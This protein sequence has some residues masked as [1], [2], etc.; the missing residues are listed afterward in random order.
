MAATPSTMLP[1]GT[2]APSFALPYVVSGATISLETFADKKALL[3]I[4]LCRHCRYVQHVKQA[5]AALGKE[6]QS[7]DLGRGYQRQ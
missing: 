2:A 6:Y 4:F 3:V 7:T 5:L 1:L